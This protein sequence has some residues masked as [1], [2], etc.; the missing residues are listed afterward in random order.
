[1]LMEVIE[2]REGGVIAPCPMHQL[3]RLIVN[4][5]GFGI[6]EH[7]MITAKHFVDGKH[8]STCVPVV[9]RIND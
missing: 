9:D 7:L 3:S 6:E 4:G 2:L 1:M 5:T 8:C